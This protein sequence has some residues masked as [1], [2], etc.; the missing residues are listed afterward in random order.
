MNFKVKISLALSAFIAVIATV[1]YAAGFDQIA[2]GYLKI[3]NGSASTKTLEF[4]VGN[5]TNDPIL[6]G[7]TSNNVSLSAASLRWLERPANGANYVELNVP[8]AMSGN[9][10][11]TLPTA[12][13]GVN[14][15][16]LTATTAGVMSFVSPL[17]VANGGTGG[18]S[19]TA[20]FDALSP[21]TTAA[22]MIVG[23]TSGTGTRFAKGTANQVIGMN[24]AATAQEYKT[25]AVGTSGSDFAV[26]N[27]ANSVTFN[28][29][30]AGASARGVMTT[31]TQ[32]VAGN[33][34]FSGDATF[35]NGISA[36]ANGAN[37]I[38]LLAGGTSGQYA[39]QVSNNASA[40]N[41]F[42]TLITAGGNS[43]DNALVVQN[44]N[45]GVQFF[46]IRGDGLVTTVNNALIKG[47]LTVGNNTT[48]DSNLG[49]ISSVQNANYYFG[50]FTA[51]WDGGFTSSPQ[52]SAVLY[53]KTGRLVCLD[54]AG[55]SA[56][57]TATSNL[58]ASAGSVPTALLPV[59]NVEQT[60]PLT[61]DSTSQQAGTV[62]L[63]TG[64]TLRIYKNASET[65]TFTNGNSGGWTPFTLCYTSA[66]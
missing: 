55:K 9:V 25:L 5:T 31:G 18:A 49:T 64:G 47:S 52:T 53:V 43:S 37:S 24:N 45:A 16:V 54:F 48:S 41:S 62:L 23:G 2:S 7:D 29:P 4:N 38:A 8:A 34:T 57:T 3:G 33:K 17:P 60:G 13:A 51:S 11:F 66:S 21:M 44:R 63:L 26:A 20:G 6:T 42:G 15:A 39:E 12:A 28:L 22:D 1:A 65:G 50:T 14:G 40:G 58:S 56:S 61:V 10:A 46:S 36:S 32:T 35:P 30:D 27:A 19:S 59:H